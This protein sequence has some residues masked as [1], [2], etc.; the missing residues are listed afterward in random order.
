MISRSAVARAVLK[1]FRSS[2]ACGYSPRHTIASARSS[3]GAAG[4]TSD[5][6][7]HRPSIAAARALDD[8]SVKSAASKHAVLELQLAALFGLQVLGINQRLRRFVQRHRGG[9]VLRLAQSR[10]RGINRRRTCDDSMR[11]R[12]QARRQRPNQSKPFPCFGASRVPF[13]FS[14]PTIFDRVYF[15]L[16]PLA[17]AS[18]GSLTGRGFTD[19]CDAFL[20]RHPPWPRPPWVV[21]LVWSPGSW[22]RVKSPSEGPLSC[23]VPPLW[24]HSSVLRP[25]RA[26]PAAPQQP[27]VLRTIT[28]RNDLHV[29]PVRRRL[30]VEQADGIS[31]F[32]FRFTSRTRDSVSVA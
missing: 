12:H 2:A 10:E 20:G 28:P 5:A 21:R 32:T 19:G 7:S 25:L 11:R 23:R 27:D 24:P 29:P 9:I 4:S 15:G 18:A 3:T 30:G 6:S 26:E 14:S 13:A 1:S 22:L 8:A 17:G 31:A 16:P